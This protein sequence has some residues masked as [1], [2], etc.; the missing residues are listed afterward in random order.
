MRNPTIMSPWLHFLIHGGGFNR[1]RTS[2]LITRHRP[3]RH[4]LRG[5][6][7][8][9]CLVYGG[10]FRHHS[11]LCTLIPPIYRLHTSRY[12]DKNPLW[13]NIC[14]CKPYILPSALPRPSWN[15]STILRLPRRLHIMKHN[16]FYWITYLFNC[17]YHIPLHYLR[18]LCCQTRGYIS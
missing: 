13:C 18:S 15:A 1:N 10:C 2:K 5:C 17:C 4:L 16:L 12:M 6:S 14:R 3:S 9:L 11:R 8:P 7:L